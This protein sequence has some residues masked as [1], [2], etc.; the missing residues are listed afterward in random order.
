MS[1]ND[2]YSS[3][4]KPDEKNDVIFEL[5]SLDSMKTNDKTEGFLNYI[6]TVGNTK[7]NSAVDEMTSKK[8]GLEKFFYGSIDESYGFGMEKLL[9]I[10][11]KASKTDVA[12]AIFAMKI[13]ENINLEIKQTEEEIAKYNE[14]KEKLTKAINEYV[15]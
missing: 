2:N 1:L 14:I 4:L 12:E 3:P 7:L 6:Y 15:P 11:D 5:P 9:S 8:T 13:L 10:E